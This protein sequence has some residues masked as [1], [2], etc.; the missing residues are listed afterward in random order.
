MDHL[1][2]LSRY[3]LSDPDNVSILVLNYSADQFEKIFSKM[4]FVTAIRFITEI[5]GKLSIPINY[6]NKEISD[7]TLIRKFIDEK[8]SERSRFLPAMTAY[9]DRFRESFVKYI[10]QKG[11]VISVRSED[12]FTSSTLIKSVSDSGRKAVYICGF[13]TEVDVNITALSCLS[14]GFFPVVVS[15][16]TSTFSERSFYSALDSMSQV[17]E[18]IDTRDLIKLWGDID[19]L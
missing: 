16:A 4:E 3:S 9:D 2:R 1:E 11:K 17:V 19:Q 8:T 13:R 14:H 6:A 15:D 18:I 7:N 5:S 12:A 10:P